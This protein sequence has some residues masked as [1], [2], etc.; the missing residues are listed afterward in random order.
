MNFV[1]KARDSRG[2][3]VEASAQAD[4]P[5]DL[6]ARLAS[7]G[8]NVIDIRQSAERA[9]GSGGKV[10]PITA[11][12]G[13]PLQLQISVP[14]A[15]SGLGKLFEPKVTLKDMVIFSRQFASM[16]K[17]GVAILRGLSVMV[18]QCENKK[19]RLVLY[20]VRRSVESGLSL[21]DAMDKHKDVFDRLYIAMVRAGEAGGILE[22]VLARL[23]DFLEVRSRLT[24]KVQAACIIPVP[25]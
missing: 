1:Y 4:S 20:S 25:L 8:M 16:V 24:Q 12:T 17:A 3:V 7:R 15:L 21:S 18:E 23:A 11:K 9:S 2:R 13:N 14:P 22:E 6:R 10:I 5:Q 19:M